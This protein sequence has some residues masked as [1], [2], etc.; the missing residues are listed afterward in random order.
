M[1]ER[2]R[3]GIFRPTVPWAILVFAFV[4]SV[5]EEPAD[6]PDEASAIVTDRPGTTNS[7]VVVPTGS[8]Q[9]ENGE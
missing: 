5:A 9:A 6:C 8:L 7:S 1:A 3:I 4:M 2:N